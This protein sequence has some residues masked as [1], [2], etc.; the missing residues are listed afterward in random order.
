M[1]RPTMQPT[2]QPEVRRW[3]PRGVVRALAG[4]A[5]VAGGGCADL[6]QSGGNE[7]L[8]PLVPSNTAPLVT[9]PPAV[10]PDGVPVVNTQ[11][12]TTTAVAA[13]PATVA[14]DDADPTSV[15]TRF[16]AAVASGD[17]AV[18]APLE[19]ANR[20]PT[21]FAWAE[22]AYEQY[23][24]LAG[25]QSW[26]VPT[27]SEPAGETSQCA[28]LQTDAAPTLQLVLEGDE[29]RVSH[30]VFTGPSEPATTGSGCIVGSIR[31]NFRGGPGTSWPRFSQLSPGT[32]G[33]TVFD[34]TESDPSQGDSWRYI[35]ADGQRGWVVDRV[36]RMQ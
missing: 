22:N 18:A 2:A 35:E 20:S 15:A 19:M 33:V 17:P 36:L 27:C 24:Q 23:T 25:A 9:V 1:V 14:T 29:W 3:V 8:P 13:G 11:G 21:V 7:T 4:L 16:L 6:I 10:G 26:G 31:V 30:P 12:T 5:L 28:W 32:C 34:A